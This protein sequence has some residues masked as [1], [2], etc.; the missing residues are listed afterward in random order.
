MVLANNRFNMQGW[1]IP[2]KLAGLVLS[3]IWIHVTETSQDRTG[4]VVGSTTQL[5]VVP[6]R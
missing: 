6:A 5:Q 1:Y 4:I 3:Q 2:K